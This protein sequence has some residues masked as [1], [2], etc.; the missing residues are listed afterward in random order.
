MFDL[1]SYIYTHLNYALMEG[2]F[3]VSIQFD[4]R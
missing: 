1:N 4:Q 2:K 3:R